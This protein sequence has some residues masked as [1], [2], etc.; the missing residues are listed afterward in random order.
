[1]R[2]CVKKRCGGVEGERR[3]GGEGVG[4]VRPVLLLGAA[5]SSSSSSIGS[6]SSSIGYTTVPLGELAGLF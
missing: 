2:Q 4:G 3:R 5:V 1:M 6:G